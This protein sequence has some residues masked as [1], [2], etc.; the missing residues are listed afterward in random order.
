MS[1]GPV[2]YAEVIGDPID[3]S[4]S[5]VI[6]GFWIE[7]LGIR[8]DYRR[9]RVER[10]GL[11]DYLKA[12][13]AD[14]AW[15]GCNVTMPLK[16]DALAIADEATD[17]AITTG[18]ANILRPRN[19]RVAAGNTDVG[20]VHE[21]VQ[22][23]VEGN[24]GPPRIVLLGSGGA[25]RAALMA[26]HLLGIRSIQIHSR[27]TT[28]AYKLAV[29]FGL[30]EEPQPFGSRADCDGLINATPLG[31]AG[32]PPLAV[33]ISGVG[34]WV[35]DFVSAPAE[36]VLLQNARAR[37][38]KTVGGLEILVEQADASFELFFGAKP[39]RDRDPELFARLRG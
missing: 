8:A 34:R 30:S 26:M 3:H 36:T 2:P 19:G 18:A 20:A 31:M 15:R 23:L 28:A 21:L 22:Q 1:D 14:P 25:A 29:Q 39:P 16:L 4:L 12:R 13:R 37:G 32:A 5:P 10:A 27:D 33:D 9:K 11:A 6:H 7:K 38:L 35:L 24:A 17:R